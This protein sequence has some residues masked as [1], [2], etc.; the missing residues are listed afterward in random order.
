MEYLKQDSCCAMIKSLR[1]KLKYNWRKYIS[2][3]YTNL[4]YIQYIQ[5]IL[6]SVFY[7]IYKVKLP[8]YDDIDGVFNNTFFI[9]NVFLNE[10]IGNSKNTILSKNYFWNY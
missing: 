6:W 8:L 3:N 7:V 4:K 10:S 9:Y 5:S 1:P 2:I